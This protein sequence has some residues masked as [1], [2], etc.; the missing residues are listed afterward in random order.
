MDLFCYT[1]ML[2]IGELIGVFA[3][4]T[5]RKITTT[6]FSNTSPERQSR[7]D[8]AFPFKSDAGHCAKGE[9]QA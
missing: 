1:F 6:R 3:H 4:C 7:E 8:F 5:N 2:I 9:M